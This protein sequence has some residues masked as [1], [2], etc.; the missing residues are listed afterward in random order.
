MN[1]GP[2]SDPLPPE[3][4][5]CVEKI[6]YPLRTF[7]FSIFNFQFSS[8]L[9][10]LDRSGRLGP[11]SAGIMSN[12]DAIPTGLGSQKIAANFEIHQFPQLPLTLPVDFYIIMVIIR[13]VI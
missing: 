7:Q 11:P 4:G 12:F 8:T 9:N 6:F 1:N 2:P 10:G 5:R 13:I 3:A